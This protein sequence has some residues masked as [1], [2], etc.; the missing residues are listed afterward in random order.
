MLEMT[1]EAAVE[2]VMSWIRRKG[3]SGEIRVMG[4]ESRDGG[5][6]DVMLSIPNGLFILKPDLSVEDNYNVFNRMLLRG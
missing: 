6:F 3:Y 4:V 1:E 5:Y 2:R